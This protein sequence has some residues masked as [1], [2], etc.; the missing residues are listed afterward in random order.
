MSREDIEFKGEGDVTLRG[1]FYPARNTTAPAPVIV[2]SHG[3]TAVKEMHIGPYA[4]VFADAGLN[5][6][7]YDHQNFGD[8]DGSQRQEVDPV[9]QY[10][11]YRNAISYACTRPEVDASQIGVWGSSFSGGLVLAIGANDTRVK[12]VVSQVPFISGP[13]IVTRM[14]RPDFLPHLREALNGDRHHR[15]GGGEPTMLPVVTPDPMS[16]A[17]MAAT[18]THDWFTK[19]AADHAPNWKNEVTVRSF[20]LIAEWDPGATIDRISPTPLLMIVTSGDVVAPYEQALEAYERAR[21][22]KQLLL[23]PGGHFDLYEGDGFAKASA[24]ARDHFLAHLRG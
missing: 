20:E 12:A 15:Y 23:L 22:P 14:V 18:E 19:T 11:D 8:S 24:A 3:L 13:G 21:E 4:E 6:L 16:Q 10:R 9:L 7:V 5:A 2:L 17:L 1:W